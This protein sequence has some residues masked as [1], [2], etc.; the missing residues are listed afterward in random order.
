[1]VAKLVSV[2]SESAFIPEEIV[3]QISVIIS[4]EASLGAVVN[5]GENLLAEAEFVPR[6]IQFGFNSGTSGRCFNYFEFPDI[7]GAMRD[8]EVWHYCLTWHVRDE[9]AVSALSLIDGSS[10][11]SGMSLQLS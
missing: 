1:M 11:Q 3:V 2:I 6:V 4:G 7:S 5:H 8:S 10:A 9:W